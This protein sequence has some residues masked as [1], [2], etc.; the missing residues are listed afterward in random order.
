MEEDFSP[1][2]QTKFYVVSLHVFVQK[3]H[4]AS[5]DSYL[6]SPWADS[7]QLKNQLQGINNVKWGPR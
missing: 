5:E 3:M 4:E 1:L 7:G 2:D 6:S